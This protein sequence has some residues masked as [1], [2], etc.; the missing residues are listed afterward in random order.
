[1]P[2]DLKLDANTHDIDF[3]EGGTLYEEPAKSLV[4]RLKI[5]ILLR[6]GEWLPNRLVGVPYQNTFFTIKN[7]KGFIDAFLQDYI[8]GVEG[9]AAIL[10]YS[11]TI[12]IERQLQVNFRVRSDNGEISNITLEV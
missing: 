5:A 9:V 1:M 4:Q 11:S 7:N 12:T 6:R 2:T 3:S 8:L 10:S